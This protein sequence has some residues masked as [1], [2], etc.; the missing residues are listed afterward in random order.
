VGRL[1]GRWQTG[2]CRQAVTGA[3]S[4]AK[5]QGA[6]LRRDLIAYASIRALRIVLLPERAGDDLRFQHAAE[7]PPIKAFLAEAAIE[8][9]VNAVLPLAARLD[10]ADPDVSL[11]QPFLQRPG[12]ELGPVVAPQVPRGPV[13]PNCRLQRP[14]HLCGPQLPA[15]D[16]I[17]AVEAAPVDDRQELDRRARAGDIKDQMQAR[18]VIEPFGADLGLR[19]RRALGPPARPGQPQF[20]LPPDALHRAPSATVALPLNQGMDPP[21]ALARIAARERHNRRF[22]PYPPIGG[23]PKPVR[24]RRAGQP[25]VAARPTPRT[26]ARRNY[27]LGCV[28]LLRRAQHF[29]RSLPLRPRGSEP[30]RPPPAV[31]G[32]SPPAEPAAPSP[33]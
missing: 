8:P 13:Q 22:R 28:A 12:H 19:P 7:Q 27:A 4:W 26:Q 5:E 24:A 18:V 33:H 32:F 16:D 3:R 2:P 9:L 14:R 31:I 6:V 10:E 20:P 23:R 30:R 21:V 25:K 1:Q 15:G 11:R 29:F 17:D